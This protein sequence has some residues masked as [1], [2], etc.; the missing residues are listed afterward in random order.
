MAEYDAGGVVFDPSQG[1]DA[2]P[3][4]FSRSTGDGKALNIEVERGLGV[5]QED[6]LPPP[7]PKKLCRT[8]VPVFSAVVAGVLFAQDNANQVLWA[9]SIVGV[10]HLG[11][12]LVVGLG[13]DLWNRDPG[14]V[15]TKGA[16][17]LNVGHG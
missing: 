10:L 1:D 17:G 15:V 16:K 12:D 6:A 14:W 4:Q 13:D 9:R 2:A 5:L 3:L 7:V 8:G 11:R